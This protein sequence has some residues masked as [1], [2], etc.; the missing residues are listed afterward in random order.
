MI[1]DRDPMCPYPSNVVTFFPDRENCSI[2]Y[3]CYDGKKYV[4]TCSPTTFWNQ[5]AKTCDYKCGK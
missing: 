1:S 2:Y 3:E 4:F 5:K